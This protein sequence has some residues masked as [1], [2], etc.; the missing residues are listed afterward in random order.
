VVSLRRKITAV[1]KIEPDSVPK[2]TPEEE[3]VKLNNGINAVNKYFQEN[4]FKVSE[5][6]FVLN[7]L[8]H[9]VL[10][11][12]ERLVAEAVSMQHEKS[13]LED[14]QRIVQ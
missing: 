6:L 10:A 2:Q 12:R 9:H 11:E 3:A 4:K 8:E 13:R 14:A 7:V 5:A 1:K